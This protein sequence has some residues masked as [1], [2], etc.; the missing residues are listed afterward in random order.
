MSMAHLLE[1]G[2]IVDGSGGPSWVGDVL[3]LD[4]RIALIGEN[5]AQRLPAGVSLGDVKRLD[6]TDKVIAPGFIDVHTH[7]DAFVLREPQCLPKVSQGVT[8]VVVGNCGISLAPLVVD[9]PEPPLNLLGQQ[10]T[11]RYPSFEAY[12]R[13]VEQI[14]PAVNVAALVGHTTLR[15]A[16]MPQLDRAATV[17]EVER[18][19]GL[20]DEALSFGAFGLSSGLFYEPANAAPSEEVLA[21]ARVVARHGGVYTSHLRDEM[22]AILEAMVEASDTAL[23]AGVPLVISHHKCAGPAN[24]GRSLQTLAFVDALSQRQPIALDAYPYLAGSTVLREDLVDGIIDVLVTWSTPHPQMSGRMLADIAE[25]WRV[26]LQEACR[27]LQPGGACYFQMQ[28]DD[29]ERILSHRLTMVGSDGLPH[30]SHPH[31]RLWGAFPRVLAHHW[32]ERGNFSLETAVHKMTGL[33]AG[34][35]R[36]A[37]RG[38]LKAGFHADV[39]VFDPQRVQDTA[40]YDKPV[41]PARGIEKV[42]VNG[43]LT[44]QEGHARIEQRAGHMLRRR[45]SSTT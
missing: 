31:P 12:G 1:S 5:L 42:F 36:L 26:D 22:A 28:E 23:E 44:Y 21:L 3:L 8:T 27:R 2:L 43:V 34:Q 38:L 16:A 37:Q 9:E 13:A 20:L 11:F 15:F 18:M 7:D 4:G 40:T 6:C 45:G 30:D 17:D 19:A 25:E 24:W 10:D 32:R 41:S 29:V 33:S 14:R 35:F 39:V